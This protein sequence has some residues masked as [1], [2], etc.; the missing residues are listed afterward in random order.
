MAPLLVS[1]AVPALSRRTSRGRACQI[2]RPRVREQ[3][4]VNRLRLF[5]HDV[6]PHR[7][8]LPSSPIACCRVMVKFALLYHGLA[9]GT[10]SLG[11]AS[12]ALM[13]PITSRGRGANRRRAI[14]CASRC[15]SW[16]SSTPHSGR[17]RA[18]AFRP[19]QRSTASAPGAARSAAVDGQRGRRLADAIDAPRDT[20]ERRIARRECGELQ[21]RGTRVDGEDGGHA[22]WYPARRNA[23]TRGGYPRGARMPSSS[24][25]RSEALSPE[26][27]STSTVVSSRSMTPVARSWVSPAA[28]AAAVGST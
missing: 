6:Q 10:L 16:R 25:M 7:A 4:D 27:V 1:T 5:C 20:P 9:P 2:D 21:A 8:P 12:S 14:S 19:Q 13:P 18:H 23:A 22:P 15:P 17:P 28:A 3:L 24:P 11:E 26:P